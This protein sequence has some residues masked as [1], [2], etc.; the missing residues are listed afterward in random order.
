MCLENSAIVI[1]MTSAMRYVWTTWDAGFKFLMVH[2]T[3][4]RS[5]DGFEFCAEK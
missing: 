5:A 4:R 2:K 1:K 3:G